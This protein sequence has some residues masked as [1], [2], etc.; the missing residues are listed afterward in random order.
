MTR[1]TNDMAMQTKTRYRVHGMDCASCA[2]K[3]NTAVR[4]LPGIDD[5]PASVPGRSLSVIHGDAVSSREIMKQVSRLGYAI[6]PAAAE[7][8]PS[9]ADGNHHPHAHEGSRAERLG[10][11]PGGLSWLSRPELRWSWHTRSV[12]WSPKRASGRSSPRC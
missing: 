8:K 11:A 9:E 12:S 10:G 1:E 7:G 4:R 5:I 6:V 3:I 2:A